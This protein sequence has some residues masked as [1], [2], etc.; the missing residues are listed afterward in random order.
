MVLIFKFVTTKYL[1]FEARLGDF[2]KGLFNL[3]MNN[4]KAILELC[5]WK[6]IDY[7]FEIFIERNG[8]FILPRTSHHT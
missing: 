8:Y 3:W 4:R 5:D 2:W 6:E 7:V 1:K